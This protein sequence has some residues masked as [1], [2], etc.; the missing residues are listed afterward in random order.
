ML[1]SPNTHICSYSFDVLTG[2]LSKAREKHARSDDGGLYTK[3][4]AIFYF[5]SNIRFRRKLFL[6]LVQ[7]QVFYAILSSS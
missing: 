5:F 3:I 4:K 1:K 2:T 7:V 6:C